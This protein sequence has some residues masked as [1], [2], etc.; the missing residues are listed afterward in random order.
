MKFI[1]DVFLIVFLFGLFGVTHSF[2]ASKKIKEKIATK[3]G[4]K[5][6][7]YR[8]FYNVSSFI[9][10]LV[11]YEIA[12]KPDFIIYDLEYPYDIIVYSLQIVPIIGLIWSINKIDLKEFIGIN[13]LLRYFNAT[14]NV[15]QLDEIPILRRDGAYKFS[16]HPIYLF[17]IMFLFLRP[18]MDLFFLTFAL[19]LT[20]YFYIGSIFEERKLIKIFGKEYLTYREQ[21]GRIF[22]K[23]F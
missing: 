19:T 16:R 22:P 17:S 10:F 21:V 2:L 12:P 1:L 11:V 4:N 6:A 5:I 20:I 9:I 8:L 23:I 14:Y 18:S 15:D 3:L 13:Q 7:F